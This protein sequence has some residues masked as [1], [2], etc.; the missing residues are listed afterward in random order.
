M[1]AFYAC[2]III[3]FFGTGNMPV[4]KLYIAEQYPTALRGKG[5]GIG[6]AAARIVGG[7]LS[8]YLIAFFLDYGGITYIFIYMLTVYIIAVILLWLWGKETAFKTVA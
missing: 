8:T 7:I 2:F 3:S 5:T 4:A 6:E 1:E